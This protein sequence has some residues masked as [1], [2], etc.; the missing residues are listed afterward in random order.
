MRHPPAETP[1]KQSKMIV[2]EL[3]VVNNNQQTPA[4]SEQR[5]LTLL[6]FAS[7]ILMTIDK[8]VPLY[9]KQNAGSDDESYVPP[10]APKVGELLFPSFN[11]LVPQFVD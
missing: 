2:A 11:L 4:S 9:L 10:P 6:K 3:E 8:T 7:T 5:S 1:E